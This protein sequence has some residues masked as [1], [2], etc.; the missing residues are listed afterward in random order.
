MLKRSRWTLLTILVLCLAT[1][2]AGCAPKATPTPVPTK[3]PEQKPTEEKPVGLPD[4][5]RI[6][7]ID[8]MTGEAAPGGEMDWMGAQLANKQRPTVAGKPVKLILV[9][10]KTDKTESALAAAR[11]IEVEKVQFIIGSWYSSLALA[12]TEVTEPAGIP[13]L[14]PTCT[15]PLITAGRPL[16][17]RLNFI[18]PY[19]GYALAKYAVQNLG[20]KTAAIL[21]DVQQDFSVGLAKYIRD[22]FIALTGDEASMLAM[23]SFQTG[24]KD[25]T[26]QLQQIKSLNPDVVF[27]PIYYIPT[28][29]MLKQAADL[30]MKPPKPYFLGSTGTDAPEFVEVAGEAAEDFRFSTSYEPTAFT[31]PLATKFK[32]DF[33]KEFG[34]DSDYSAVCSFD[35]YNIVLDAIEKA[36]TVEAIKLTDTLRAFA[37]W[38]GAGG[39]VTFD[40][41]GDPAKSVVIIRIENGKRVV[42]TIVQPD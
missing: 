34:V 41:N 25:F 24:D 3:A 17:F 36:G 16:N 38:E 26:A 32:E 18:D 35:S 14:T 10:D 2:L 15:N 6:G 30:G 7:W 19:Q 8:A 5:I 42:D 9:D 13:F 28:A 1:V 21:M 39:M 27:A 20:A 40:E 23:L 37:G 12:A 29:L 4:E 22:D 11:L 33:Q 31:S